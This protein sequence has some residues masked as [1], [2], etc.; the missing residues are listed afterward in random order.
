MKVL[1]ISD[2]HGNLDNVEKVIKNN[3]RFD[4]VIHLGDIIGQDDT[5]KN[6]CECPIITVKGNCDYYTENK[7]TEVFELENNKIMA[8][9]GHYYSVD[10]GLDKLY[11]GAQERHCNIAMYGHT[12]VPEIFEQGDV[13]I[14]NP[15]SISRP[16]QLN[17]RPS[18]IVMDI[19]ESGKASFAIN[20]L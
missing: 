10:W 9:H 19:D 2:S 11:Y 7:V 1:V 5:L 13:T 16:R 20:Y 8:T 14:I 3:E 18:Y 15:G 17:H 6:M 12:H 4:M